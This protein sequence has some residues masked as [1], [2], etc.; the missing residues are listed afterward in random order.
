MKQAGERST[1]VFKQYYDLISNKALI[2]IKIQALFFIINIFFFFF[3]K[4]EMAKQM[5]VKKLK[6]LKT[7]D[8]KPGETWKRNYHEFIHYV[9]IHVDFIQYNQKYLVFVFPSVNVWI[10]EKPRTV[11][12]QKQKN[13]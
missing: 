8:S 11:N 6:N 2:Q 4:G 13:K 7:L 5:K 9:C 1:D 10:T 3:F 12:F